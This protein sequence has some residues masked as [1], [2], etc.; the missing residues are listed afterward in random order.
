MEASYISI[1]KR[2][3]IEEERVFVRASSESAA[4]EQAFLTVLSKGILRE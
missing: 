4:I 3:I 1:E 2:P